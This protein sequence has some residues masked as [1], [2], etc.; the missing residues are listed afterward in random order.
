MGHG[1]RVL[2]RNWRCPLGEIDLVLGAPSLVVFCEVKAR[3][4]DGFGGPAAAVDNAKQRRIRRV[5]AAWLA[6]NRPGPVQ[7]RFDV[8]TLVGARIEVIEAAF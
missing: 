6:V 3:A 1:Y 7:V 8:V 5:A 4:G 2:A